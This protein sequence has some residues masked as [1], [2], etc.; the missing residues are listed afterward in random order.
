MQRMRINVLI[1]EKHLKN[2]LPRNYILLPRNLLTMFTLQFTS[3]YMCE[4]CHDKLFTALIA[5]Y[6]MV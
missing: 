2:A 4:M 5:I 1:I 3:Y 6:P